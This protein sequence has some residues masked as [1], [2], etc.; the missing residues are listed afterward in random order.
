MNDFFKKIIAVSAI[1]AVCL[2]LF[3]G[4]RYVTGNL[5]SFVSGYLNKNLDVSISIDKIGVGLPLCLK[6]KGVKIDDSVDIQSIHVYLDPI[7]LRLKDKRVV[8]TVKIIRPSVRIKRESHGRFPVPVLLHK[9]KEKNAPS[10]PEPRFYLSRIR[11]YNGSLTYEAGE[12]ILEIIDIRGDI[13]NP[14]I[15]FSGDKLC[16]FAARGF[17]KNK[18][19]ELLSSLKIDGFVKPGEKVKT[20]LEAEDVRLSVLGSLYDRYLSNVIEDGKFDIKS[21]IDISDE[22]LIAKCS[23][24][25]KD[26][27]FKK[28]KGTGSG[29]SLAASFILLVNFKNN[30]VKI[31][32]LQGNFL[33]VILD[34]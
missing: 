1:A 3:L 4:Y 7:S 32:N 27:V 20:R 11:V 14:G 16:H 10:S 22:N 33:K 2:S 9:K 12:D 25:G 28:N 13:E 31:K 18:N 23:L 15:F 19:P 8:A 26:P 21:D 30:L 17:I 34:I 24:E 6:L 5:A 29:D